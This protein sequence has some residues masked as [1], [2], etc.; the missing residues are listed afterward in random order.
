MFGWLKNKR[1][2]NNQETV[3]IEPQKENAGIPTVNFDSSAVTKAIKSNLRES[4]KL[5]KEVPP[6]KSDVVYKAAL[7]SIS[8]GRDLSII[9][10]ALMTINGMSKSRA[11]KIS[12]SLN[13]KYTALIDADRQTKLGIKYAIWRYSGIP[14]SDA[15]EAHKT[16]DGKPYLITKGMFLNGK[17]TWPGCEDGCRCTSKSMI[18]GFDGYTGGTPKGY[19][20]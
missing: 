14:C 7:S 13:N 20:E 19:V 12:I 2:S 11:S 3:V 9:Y 16:A 1:I 6:D 8:K 10:K 18:E 17:W 4:I 15:N 5:I